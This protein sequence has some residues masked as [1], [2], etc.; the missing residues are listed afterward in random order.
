[1]KIAMLRMIKDLKLSVAARDKGNGQLACDIVHTKDRYVEVFKSLN[2][3]LRCLA[4]V[5]V[6]HL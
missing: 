2:D 4:K 3:A 5:P 6:E 1:M